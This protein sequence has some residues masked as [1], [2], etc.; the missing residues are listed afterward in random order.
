MYPKI[1]MT[2]VSWGFYGGKYESQAK[3]IREV[4]SYNK[5]LENEWSPDETV[6]A[7]TNVTIQYFYWDD[8]EDDDVEEDFNLVADTKIGFT[9]GE[10]LYKIHNQVVD[11]LE[12]A[13]HH[14][15]EG[16]TLWEGENY[17]KPNAPLYFLNQ[18][19]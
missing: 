5:D 15:F 9:A 11:K 14:F 16:L 18:G 2:D 13:D 19:S 1:L 8:K 10:L 17:S 12:D 4:I 6:L 7:N 3:F